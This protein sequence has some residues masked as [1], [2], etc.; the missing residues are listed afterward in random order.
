MLYFD[1]EFTE[2]TLCDDLS[3]A[4]MPSIHHEDRERGRSE[5]LHKTT[6]KV[7]TLL[8]G[9]LN[10]RSKSSP[11]RTGIKNQNLLKEM[12]VKL[13]RKTITFQKVAR[14]GEVFLFVI[15]NDAK[16]KKTHK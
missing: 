4:K 9:S 15:E 1:S 13:E 12:Q 3:K 11:L 5:M 16:M 8:P 6:E 2:V 7:L 14:A 10:P